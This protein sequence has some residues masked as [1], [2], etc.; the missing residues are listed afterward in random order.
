MDRKKATYFDS[1]TV[2]LLRATLDDAWACV[3]PE[4]RAA[5]SQSILA[6]ALLKSAATGERNPERLRDA[7]LM[8]ITASGSFAADDGGPWAV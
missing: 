6:E 4:L 2:S 5:T 3:R 1:E 8:A 7:A